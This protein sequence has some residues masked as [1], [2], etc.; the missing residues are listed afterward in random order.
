MI[1]N[2]AVVSLLPLVPRP[3]I[4]RISRR[5][6]AGRSL[7]EA[8]P[9]VAELNR[10]DMTVT[11]D[12][13]GEDC[14]NAAEVTASRDLYL[15]ALEEF[16][17]QGLDCNI[18][19]KLSQMGLR[20]DTD[21][22]R[23]VTRELVEAARDRN[24]FVRIDME[25]SSVTQATLDIYQELR[26]TFSDHVG[27]VLQSC[28]HRSYRDLESLLT[29]G[30]TNVRICKGIYREGPAVALQ[31]REEVRESYL[32]LIELLFTHGAVK[33]AV[34]THDPPL[35]SGTLEMI[36]RFKVPRERYEFQMLFGVAEKLRGELVAAGHPLRVYVP[37]GEAWYPYSTRRLRENPQIAG[38][39]MK[40]LF[41]RN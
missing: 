30:P 9:R 23:S 14:Q 8:L 4:W 17:R 32:N 20:F 40:N 5:Y 15:Q 29:E 38:Y 3:L 22:C 41:R 21:L 26:E 36:Q 11:V 12:V 1:L 37:F 13:L 35:V 2:R 34:A 6:I 19:I 27:A 7:A 31:G 25:D 16:K 24:N 28:L 33:T 18:S 39:V 10:G